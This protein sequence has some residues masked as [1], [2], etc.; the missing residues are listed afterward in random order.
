[1][2]DSTKIQLLENAGVLSAQE[3]GAAS[4]TVVY[5]AGYDRILVEIENT[6]ALS[7]TATFVAGNGMA[8][9]KG[10]LS[11]AIAT[12]ETFMFSE[13]ESDR[14]KDADGKVTLNLTDAD[15]SAF[16]G[17]ITNV[18]VRVFYLPKAL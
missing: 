3:N 9:S 7:V 16:S 11:Q 14:F 4:Q 1:M 15:G 2:A 13:L 5:D 6:D 12:T 8:A 10:D 17:T 18:K